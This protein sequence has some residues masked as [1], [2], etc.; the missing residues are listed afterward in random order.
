MSLAT[1]IITI[2]TF[3]EVPNDVDN[4]KD[5]ATRAEECQVGAALVAHVLVWSLPAGDVV[6]YSLRGSKWVLWVV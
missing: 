5:E 4:A 2:S 6:K 1:D 3:T